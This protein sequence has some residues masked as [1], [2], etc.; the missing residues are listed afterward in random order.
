MLADALDI[1]RHCMH[2]D[3]SVSVPLEQLYYAMYGGY[4]DHMSCNK[5]VSN[6]IFSFVVSLQNGVY[7]KKF[8]ELSVPR[9]CE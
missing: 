5:V 8:V 6:G 1:T 9:G 3:T 4:L 2:Y 7:T